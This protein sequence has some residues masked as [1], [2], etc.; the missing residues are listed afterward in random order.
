MGY[1]V[2]WAELQMRYIYQELGID[3]KL[4]PRDKADVLKVEVDSRLKEFLK[5]RPV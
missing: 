3:E 5:K 2:G 4:H 1:A